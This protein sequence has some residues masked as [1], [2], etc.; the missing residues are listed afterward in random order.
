M[1]YFPIFVDAKQ[2]NVL[3]VGGGE[4]ASRKVDLLLKTPALV[5]VV[6]P[7]LTDSL[8]ALL[9]QEKIMHI[10]GCYQSNLLQGR[11]LVFVATANKSLNQEVSEDAR[12]AG[13]LANV[14]DSPALCHFITPSIIERAPMTFAISSEGQ[15]PVLVRYWRERLEA[16]IPQN[17]GQIAAFAGNK[18]AKIKALLNNVTKRRKFWESFFSSSRSQQPDQLEALYQQRLD[19]AINEQSQQGELYVIETP[20]HSDYLSLAALR[21]MQ[22]SDIA[23]FEPGVQ[24]VIIDLI[25]RD[26]DRESISENPIIQILSRINNGQRVSYL[27]NTALTAH[28]EMWKTLRQKG[29]VISYFSSAKEFS[30]D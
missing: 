23:F 4:V 24:P 10:D 2:L 21:H 17:L 11:Q 20:A 3:V 22:Q 30:S 19:T 6:S 14:V 28:S 8:R 5:T 16:L 29:V 15:S 1:Q 12:Q 27:S 7:E 13:V 25:R 26:A 9:Q 18:R